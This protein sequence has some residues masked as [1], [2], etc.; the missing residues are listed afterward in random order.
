MLLAILNVSD[1]NSGKEDPDTL[2]RSTG[3]PSTT[4]VL[5]PRRSV[6]EASTVLLE[7]LRLEK[8]PMGDSK[9][10]VRLYEQCSCKQLSLATLPKKRELTG[11]PSMCEEGVAM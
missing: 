1:S 10:G 9:Q 2:S 11:S 3:G 5:L 6:S 8:I 7:S 4:E